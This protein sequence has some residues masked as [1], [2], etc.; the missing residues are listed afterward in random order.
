MISSTNSINRNIIY[1]AKLRK[2]AIV[3]FS[4]S[5]E[6][7][8]TRF[9]AEV[10]ELGSFNSFLE[11]TTYLSHYQ[12]RKLGL[13]DITVCHEN[14]TL[15]FGPVG[16]LGLIPSDYRRCGIGQYCLS[17]LIN[18][19]KLHYSEYGVNDGKLADVD[20]KDEESKLNRNN[21][22]KK[23]GFKLSLSEDGEYG[24]FS[25]N[26]LNE[27]STSW[28]K[29]KVRLLSPYVISKLVEKTTNLTERKAYLLK[30]VCRLNEKQLASFKRLPMAFLSGI[31]L[32]YLVFLFVN[33]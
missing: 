2:L 4:T 1:L 28:N 15:Q 33:S 14:Q 20:A 17:N 32:G 7:N 8:Q 22:Y 3:E 23:L 5:T 18:G 9:K 12:N 16:H 10:K 24:S 30:E 31:F 29:R 25:C 11:P 13:F 26:H 19:V 6:K 27:L 21:F